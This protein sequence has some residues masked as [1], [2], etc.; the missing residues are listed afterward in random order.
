MVFW[1]LWYILFSDLIALA[2][3]NVPNGQRL[4]DTRTFITTKMTTI[5]RFT[6]YDPLKTDHQL[7]KVGESLY[8]DIHT[9][10][11]NR[12]FILFI[13]QLFP[14]HPLPLPQAV[15]SA[16][17][18]EG[19]TPLAIPKQ[20][21]SPIACSFVQLLFNSVISEQ[22]TRWYQRENRE[23]QNSLSCFHSWIY[24]I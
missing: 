5:P 13:Q 18:L 4:C 22:F 10:K 17:I 24:R 6:V 2:Q 15:Y 14:V 19:C 8:I 1:L 20:Q 21:L 7:H 12:I 23:K 11:L 3:W 9:H 16:R